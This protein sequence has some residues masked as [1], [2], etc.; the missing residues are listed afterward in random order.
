ME[1]YAPLWWESLC[2]EIYLTKQKQVGDW[3][4]FTRQ[5]YLM[6]YEEGLEFKWHYLRRRQGC[7][8]QEYTTLFRE[9]VHLIEYR[10]VW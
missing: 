8:V 4:E 2:Q 5:F 10:S 7:G 3:E 1:G 6:G 9:E